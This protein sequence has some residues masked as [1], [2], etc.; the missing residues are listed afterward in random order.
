MM[1]Q[2]ATALRDRGLEL[3]TRWLQ[4]VSKTKSGRDRFIRATNDYHAVLKAFMST[5]KSKANYDNLKFFH[6]EILDADNAL[7]EQIQRTKALESELS[8]VDHSLIER[9]RPPLYLGP[10]LIPTLPQPNGAPSCK[11]LDQESTIVDDIPAIVRSYF[12]ALADLKLLA[13]RVHYDLPGEY[14]EE[15]AERQRLRNQE[16]VPGVSNEEFELHFTTQLSKAQQ[17]LQDQNTL[18]EEL[19]QQCFAAGYSTDVSHYTKKSESISEAPEFQFPAVQHWLKDVSTVESIESASVI[20]STMLEVTTDSDP[21]DLPEPVD[22]K[23]LDPGF[24]VRAPEYYKIGVVFTTL[25]SEPAAS[26]GS[27]GRVPQEPSISTNPFNEKV[28]SKVRR[29]VVIRE[30]PTSVTALPII[31]YGSRGVA[32]P[33]IKKSDH[34]IIYTGNEPAPM[35]GETPGLKSEA[36]KVQPAGL[37]ERLKDESRIDFGKV[38]TIEHDIKTRPF[39]KVDPAF[40]QT[41]RMHYMQTFLQFGEPA[42]DE[43]VARQQRY[44]D[45]SMPI[46][47][48]SSLLDDPS[49][50]GWTPQLSIA[51]P[52]TD[53]PS[54]VWYYDEFNQPK[55]G[56]DRQNSKFIYEDGSTRLADPGPMVQGALNSTNTSDAKSLV[57]RPGYQLLMKL[58]SEAGSLH[59][60]STRP[61]P[62]PM[63]ILS[64]LIDHAE[65]LTQSGVTDRV[66]S[67]GVRGQRSDTR[68]A[69]TR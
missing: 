57:E 31:S 28:Y 14:Q 49:R 19:Q 22:D 41:L 27:H 46:V 25:W 39:G 2:D 26:A 30:G 62:G 64:Q 69:R 34:A 1:R 54:V 20:D 68:K 4:E 12:D 37:G 43:L 42:T 32:K 16:R 11:G 36:I 21:V 65:S 10:G 35:E 66:P 58:L 56:Y 48:G 55:F 24:E 3:Q 50:T 29:F 61:Q 7:Q 47:S 15:S 13:E 63:S 33:G 17:E 52:D 59:M 44:H 67:N 40:M 38:Y 60:D 53:G 5:T 51:D 45:G 23:K 8:T 6:Q 18:V 9:E